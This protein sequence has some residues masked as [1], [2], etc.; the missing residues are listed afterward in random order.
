ML[1]SA[2]SDLGKTQFNNSYYYLEHQ[3]LFGL[4][5][6]GAYRLRDRLFYP[7]CRKLKKIAFPVARYKHFISCARFY[8]LRFHD[9]ASTNRCADVRSATL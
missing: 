2:S 1:A 8:A 6:G 9:L 7:V 4:T 3:A 5:L